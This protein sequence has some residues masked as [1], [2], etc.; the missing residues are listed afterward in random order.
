MPTPGEHMTVQSRILQYAQDIGWTF[1]PRAEAEARRGFNPEGVTLAERAAK[2][3]LYFD[4]L[5]YAEG[6]RIQSAIHR[7]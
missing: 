7:E 4:D 5:L 3:S 1:V 6:P 2:A